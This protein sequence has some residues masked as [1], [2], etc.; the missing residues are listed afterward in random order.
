[1]ARDDVLLHLIMNDVTRTIWLWLRQ[2][3]RQRNPL[4]Q[5]KVVVT[6]AT[7]HLANNQGVRRLGLYLPLEVN[8]SATSQRKERV[9]D[10]VRKFLKV[11]S[12]HK[13]HKPRK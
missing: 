12:V 8:I 3:Q 11:P 5:T 13:L 10:I 9:P 2:R 7:R 4:K 1:M 6:L